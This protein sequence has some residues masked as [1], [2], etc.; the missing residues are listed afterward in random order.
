MVRVPKRP[1]SMTAS[2]L[3]IS[4]PS[5]GT[6]PFSSMDLGRGRVSGGRARG[7]GDVP[8]SS[9]EAHGA[10]P[11]RGP[12]RP[13]SRTGAADRP[14][15]PALQFGV[16]QW[17]GWRAA[18]GGGVGVGGGAA[19]GPRPPRAGGGPRRTRAGRAAPPPT[20]GGGC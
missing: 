18:V 1:L 15:A 16:F 3:V 9:I 5:K 10:A 8:R 11:L 12:R 6:S 20:G 17:R 13:L 7:P 4:G 14:D 2:A 19:E